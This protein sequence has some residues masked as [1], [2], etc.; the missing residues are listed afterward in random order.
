MRLFVTTLRPGHEAN[1][2]KGRIG[3][4]FRVVGVGR[5][6]QQHWLPRL[7]RKSTGIIGGDIDPFVDP[8]ARSAGAALADNE[9]SPI[10]VGAL[11]RGPDWVAVVPDV[12]ERG[13][14]HGLPEEA[15]S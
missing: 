13:I 5:D 2:R 6:R 9:L 15:P 1:V 8:P 10:R 4:A 12:V 7:P 14:G 3:S 11:A